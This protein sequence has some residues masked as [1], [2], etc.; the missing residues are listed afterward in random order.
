V[1]DHCLLLMSTAGQGPSFINCTRKVLMTG[2]VT[3]LPPASTVL[4]ILENIDPDPDLMEAC[5]DLKKRGYRFALDDFLA[6]ES[7]R[8]FLE[9][10]DFIKVDFLAS[11]PAARLKIYA[12][13]STSKAR[14][15]LLLR[16]CARGSFRP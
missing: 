9:I 8:P 2:I 10:A 12:M 6:E 11:D 3:L 16:G 14:L 7:K 15:P 1:I 4:E 13:A 5:K